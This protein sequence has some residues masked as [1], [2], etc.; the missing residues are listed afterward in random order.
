MPTTRFDFF[1]RIIDQTLTYA[2]CLFVFRSHVITEFTTVLRILPASIFSPKLSAMHAREFVE[3]PASSRLALWI[4]TYSVHAVYHL[5]PP[6]FRD[7]TSAATM[8][9]L[10]LER[11]DCTL[12]NSNRSLMVRVQSTASL[13][14]TEPNTMFCS[15]CNSSCCL[16]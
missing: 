12:F 14:C 6:L 7:S 15:F 16:I 3:V 1:T 2:I 10:F 5:V 13:P 11:T 8:H 4:Y 9:P